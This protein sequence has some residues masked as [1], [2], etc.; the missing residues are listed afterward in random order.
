MY[1]H[2]I[3][4]KVRKLIQ[5]TERERTVQEVYDRINMV[6]KDHGHGMCLVKNRS[7]LILGQKNTLIFN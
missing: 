2:S 7:D 1:V 5:K 4:S 6:H 3:K